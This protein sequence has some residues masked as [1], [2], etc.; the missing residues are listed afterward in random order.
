MGFL[1]YEVITFLVYENPKDQ[2]DT[3]AKIQIL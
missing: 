1:L 3:I 2:T